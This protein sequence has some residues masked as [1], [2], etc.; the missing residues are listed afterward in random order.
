MCIA[1]LL[2]H[3]FAHLFIY[4]FLIWVQRLYRA[5]GEVA[6]HQYTMTLGLPEFS[7][8]KTNAANL[9]EVSPSPAE[10]QARSE[11][12]M[13]CA[14]RDPTAASPLFAEVSKKHSL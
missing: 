8:A 13:F 4:L 7:R 12:A 3:L 5:A 9:S 6:R 11:A 10:V 1:S 14:T 2:T